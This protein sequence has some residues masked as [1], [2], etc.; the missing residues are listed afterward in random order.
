MSGME[1]QI[2]PATV[3]PSNIDY[4]SDCYTQFSTAGD[5]YIGNSVSGTAAGQGAPT[6]DITHPGLISVT[7]GTTA[8]GRSSL[9]SLVTS[10]VLFGGGPYAWEGIVSIPTLSTVADRFICLFGFVNSVSAAPTAG[11]F[12]SYSD[13]VNGG[14]WLVTAI[15]SSGSVTTDTGI[16]VVAGTF[17][18]LNVSVN[19]AGTIATFSIN[20]VVVARITTN[21]PVATADACGY[22]HTIRKTAGLNSRSFVVDYLWLR[23]Q[24][25]ASR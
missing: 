20:G 12:F 2:A 21:I 10:S 6:V 1:T 16:P 5:G 4:F 24:P 17:Y 19:A 18:K 11:L 3:G 8:A 22:T 25:T 14:N 9:N 13:N 23:H 15:N 7:T